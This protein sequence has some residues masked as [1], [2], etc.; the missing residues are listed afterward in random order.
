MFTCSACGY[1]AN[2]DSAPACSLCGTKK[3]G[4]G[5]G[6]GGDRP[7]PAP[8]KPLKDLSKS[9]DDLVKTAKAV[10]EAADSAPVVTKAPE[11]GAA[12]PA[13]KSSSKGSPATRSGGAVATQTS[14][15]VLRLQQQPPPLA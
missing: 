10:A 2:P 14:T 6:G 11:K 1:E 3:P 9:D 13:A 12:K 4:A 15:G 7:A 5:G 8:P